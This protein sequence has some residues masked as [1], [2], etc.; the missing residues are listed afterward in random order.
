MRCWC[1]VLQTLTLCCNHTPQD[2]LPHTTADQYDHFD[3]VSV[4]VDIFQYVDQNKITDLALSCWSDDFNYIRSLWWNR[5]FFCCT[6]NDSTIS[7]LENFQEIHACQ[8]SYLVKVNELCYTNKVS[9]LLATILHCPAHKNKQTFHKAIITPTRV[10]SAW[11]QAY[12]QK[13]P[14]IHYKS[15]N[16]FS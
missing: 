16:V 10:N 2:P 12:E 5:S 1:L 3:L 15:W 8:Q 7:L 9:A 6:H 11:V 13:N 4:S 14:V